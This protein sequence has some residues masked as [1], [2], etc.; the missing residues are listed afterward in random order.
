LEIKKQKSICCTGLR[1]G[2]GAEAKG[3]KANGQWTGGKM[4]G[5]DS[6]GL[7]IQVKAVPG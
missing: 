3:G 1:G 6:C 5:E 4:T 7:S 2:Q